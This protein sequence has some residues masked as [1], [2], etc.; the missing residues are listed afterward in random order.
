MWICRIIYLYLLLIVRGIAQLSAVLIRIR[1]ICVVIGAFSRIGVR[2]FIGGKYR[3]RCGVLSS[4]R[5]SILGV[6]MYRSVYV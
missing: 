6:Y 1:S 3:G 4:R 5:M 2:G